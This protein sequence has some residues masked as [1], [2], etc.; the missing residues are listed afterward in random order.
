MGYRNYL[1]VVDKKQINKIRKMSKDE[2]W[3]FVD[4]EPED[5]YLPHFLDICEK[6]NAEEAIELGKYID[7]REKLEKFFVPIFKEKEFNMQYNEEEEF[8]IAKP[9]ILQELATIYKEKIVACYKDLLNEKSTVE[10][11][12]RSQID[13]LKAEAISHI[14]WSQYLDKLSNNKYQLGGGWLYEHGVFN[15]LFLMKIFNPKIQY[16]LWLGY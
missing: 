5:D 8:C 4:E 13:R 16:L 3:E 6:I 7:Y 9:E 15:I 11:D 12:K 14:N 1:Y 2:L 10:F